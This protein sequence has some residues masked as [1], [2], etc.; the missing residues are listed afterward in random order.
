MISGKGNLPLI[1]PPQFQ[2]PDNFQVFDPEIEDA[3]TKSNTG[4]SGTRTFKYII[5]PLKAGSYTIPPIEFAFF[6]Y[7]MVN[8]LL[9]K[10][11]NLIFKFLIQVMLIKI[12]KLLLLI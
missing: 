7:L 9:L 11:L 8:S 2:L 12:L 1:N 3:F 4:I 6:L 10:L 5:N